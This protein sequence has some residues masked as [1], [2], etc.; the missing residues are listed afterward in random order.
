MRAM[1]ERPSPMIE[2]ACMNLMV[3]SIRVVASLLMTA[4]RSTTCSSS[5]TRVVRLLWMVVW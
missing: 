3:V 4:P 1:R 2:V 5:P